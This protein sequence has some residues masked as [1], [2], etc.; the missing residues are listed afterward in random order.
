MC[1][2]AFM[3]QLDASIVSLA[4]PP[5]QKEFGA[6]AGS[7]QWVALSYLLTLVALVAPVGRVSDW[8]GRKSVYVYGFGVFTVASLL[9]ALAPNLTTLII[10]RVL[11]A[12][13]AA[14]L[15]AN[16]V[17]LI[18]TAVPR[19]S[20]SKAI[21]VQGA[22][23]AI[24]LAL[25]PTVGG[26]L[27]SLGDWRLIF[28][29]NIPFGIIGITAGWFLLPQSQSL[30]ERTRFDRLGLALFV[31]SIVL[32]VL[33][34]SFVGHPGIAA[35]WPIAGGA[36]A[37][38]IGAVF[39][40][41]SRRTPHP[42][43][44]LRLFASR[45]FSTGIVSGLLSYAVLFGVLFA[46]PMASAHLQSAA[47]TG[48]VL[49]ILPVTLALV[50]PIA[51]YLGDRNGPRLVTSIGMLIAAIGLALIGALGSSLWGLIVGLVV[52]G[53]GSGVFTPANNASIMASAPRRQ[54]GAASGILN[55][56]RGLG[57]AFGVTAATLAVGYAAGAADL[58]RGMSIAMYGFCV[59]ALVAALACVFGGGARR[60]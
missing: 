55:M 8:L 24:G 12:V 57:T 28:A 27:V 47:T 6:S 4:L 25:G 11:Q 50:A 15:Q 2:G 48:L 53:I 45:T 14:M 35:L 37:L 22:A 23:Q 44:D 54:S 9:C 42:L 46:V 1:A 59:A 58:A 19:D 33:A 18:A 34:L 5:M 32:L 16:S 49:T 31:P 52:L 40:V 51:G 21:G 13:G 36:L 56:T 38:T 7:V 60:T 43:I 29:V 39:L 17:A 41:R 20:L 3:G 30:A 26:L 10:F